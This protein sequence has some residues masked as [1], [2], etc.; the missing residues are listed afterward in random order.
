LETAPL[1]AQAEQYAQT[2]QPNVVKRFSELY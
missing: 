1:L 2:A